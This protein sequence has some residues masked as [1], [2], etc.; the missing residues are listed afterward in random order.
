MYPRYDEWI[1]EINQRDQAI[2]WIALVA[3]FG[4][5]LLRHLSPTQKLIFYL[6]SGWVIRIWT[7]LIVVYLVL[8]FGR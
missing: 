7:L 1:Q 2:V 6:P 4:V 8:S 3:L 5:L